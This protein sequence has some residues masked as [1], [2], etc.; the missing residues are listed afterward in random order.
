[1]ILVD[2]S[3]VI[4]SNLMVQLAMTKTN[5]IDESLIRHMILNSLKSYRSKFVSDYGELVICCDDRNSWRKDVFEYYKSNRKKDRAASTLDW[6]KIFEILNRI[7]D[8]LKNNMPYKQL[9]VATAE[10]DDIIGSLCNKYGSLNNQDDIEP[11]L[12]ISGDKDFIQLQKY[13]NV[14]QYG[15]VLKKMMY[16]NNP[17][18]F[19]REHIMLGDTGD[20]IPNFLSDNDTFVSGKRQRSIMRKK[21]SEWCVMKPEDFCNASMLSSY[22]RN[23]RLIDLD[24]IPNDIQEQCIEHFNSVPIA[25]RNGMLAYFL[26]HKLKTMIEHIDAF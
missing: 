14:S 18:R 20:G 19:K 21:L 17:E 10:A 25:S 22:V 1:M 16:E 24:Y 23:Q 5:T 2:F 4:I 6:T 3:Q 13:C 26:K 8:E 15:P 7:S 12:I 9:R 11:I